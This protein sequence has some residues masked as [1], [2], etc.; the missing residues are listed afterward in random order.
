[1]KLDVKNDVPNSAVIAEVRAAGA[2]DR[3]IIITCDDN[4]AVRVHELAPA[5][6]DLGPH[7]DTSKAHRT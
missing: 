1:L 4:A 2:M 5:D 3:V 6:H 7:C